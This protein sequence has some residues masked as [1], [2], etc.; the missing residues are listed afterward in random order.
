[1]PKFV[2]I[3]GRTKTEHVSE[4]DDGR[5]G[6]IRRDERQGVDLPDVTFAFGHKFII[7]QPT[8]VTREA[9]PSDE[10]FRKALSRIETHPHF[11]PFADEA[12]FTMVEPDKRSKLGVK[13]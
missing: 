2:Y 6:L 3:G 13:S 5:G 8:E 7:N 12:E 10:H 4:M 9:F 1:M 11:K